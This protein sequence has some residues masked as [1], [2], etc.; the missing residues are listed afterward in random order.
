MIRECRSELQCRLDR[1]RGHFGAARR[2][3]ARFCLGIGHQGGITGTRCF[4]IAGVAV[5]SAFVFDRRF[6]VT[7]A[8]EEQVRQQEPGRRGLWRGIEALQVQA[9]PADRGVAVNQKRK[10]SRDEGPLG[11]PRPGPLDFFR[12]G[13]RFGQHLAGLIADDVRTATRFR[14]R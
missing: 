3:G 7:L 11:Q 9:I 1:A 6:F 10:H 13:R 2:G 5:G 4:R 12:F 14:R 8:I